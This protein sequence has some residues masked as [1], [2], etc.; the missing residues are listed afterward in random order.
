[1]FGGLL[2]AASV[3]SYAVLIASWTVALGACFN[4]F[5]GDRMAWANRETSEAG[6][7]AA[8][9]AGI[10]LRVKRAISGLTPSDL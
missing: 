7:F 9:A 1:M 8:G 3:V 2:P 4:N 10:D 6:E 5:T